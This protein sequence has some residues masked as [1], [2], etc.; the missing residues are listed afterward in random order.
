MRSKRSLLDATGGVVMAMFIAGIGSIMFGCER[1][2]VTTSSVE[3]FNDKATEIE[4]FEDLERSHVVSN[5][6]ALHA[7]FI[8]ADKSDGWVTYDERVAEAKRRMWLSDWFDEPSTESA[9]VGWI[10]T[11]ACRITGIRGGLTMRVVGPIPRYAVR[12]LTHGDILIAKKESQSFS[13]LEFVDFLTRLGRMSKLLGGDTQDEL[14][15]G[16]TNQLTPA[17]GTPV[18]VAPPSGRFE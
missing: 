17:G 1:A 4:F 16:V 10:A 14:P 15:V 9:Q 8:F 6:D 13:G 11:A 12:E 5:N 7:L 18:K 3:K 2:T